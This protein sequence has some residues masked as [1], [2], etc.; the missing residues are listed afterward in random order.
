MRARC[1]WWPPTRSAPT[2]SPPIS[3]VLLAGALGPPE[4]DDPQVVRLPADEILPYDD[5]SPDRGTVLARLGALFHLRRGEGMRAVVVGARGLAQRLLPVAEIDAH[6]HSVAAGGPCDRDQLARDLALA[7][8]QHVPLVEDPG[9]FSVRG[10][11]VD[12]FSPLYDAPARLELFGDEIESIRFFNPETQRT[13]GETTRLRLAPARETLFT[14]KTIRLATL[15]ARELAAEVGRPTRQLRSLVDDIEQGRAAFG[16]EALLPGFFEGPLS[17]LAD[18][19]EGVRLAYVEDPEAVAEAV[20]GLWERA[21]DEFEAARGRGELAFPAERHYLDPAGALGVL[22]TMPVVAHVPLLVEGEATEA[23]ALNLAPTAFLHQEILDHHGED[24]ALTPLI[25]HLAAWRERGLAAVLA[26]Q[27]AGQADRLGRLLL[28]RRVMV[29]RHD[30]LPDLTRAGELYDP[31]VGAHLVVGDLDTGFVDPSSQV[32]LLSDADVLGAPPTRRR[33]ARRLTDEA[34]LASAFRELT[35]GDLVVHVEHGIGRYAGL[36]RLNL[37]GV[38]G[39]FLVVEYAGKDKIYLPVH[40]L[41]Q[42]QKYVGGDPEHVRLDR[43]GGQAF[44]VRKKKVKEELLKMAAELLDIYA[45]RKAHPGTAFSAPDA[46]FRE[47]EAEFPYEETVDQAEAIEAVLADMQRVEPMD[48]LVCG[49]VGFGKTE[50]AMRA[51]MKAVL[52]GKQV[53]V[54]VPTTVLAVQHARTFAARFGGYPVVVESLSRFRSPKEVKAVLKRVAEGK[55]DIL[56]GTHRLLS[57]DVS[58]HDLGLLVVDEEQR[59]GVKQK[60]ALK[61]LRR[62]VDVLTLTATPIPRTLHLS[63]SG[64][65]DLSIIATAPQDRRAVRTFVARFDGAVIK[66]AIERELQRGGQVF[67]VH[68]RVQSI[69]GVARYLE[70]LMPG[71]RMVVA[72]GQMHEHQLE[73]AMQAFISREVDVLLSSAII[74]SGLDIPTV[75]TIL[76]D[77]AD[78][79][80]LAQLYQLRGRVG[81]G[82][83]RAYCYL[84]VPARRPITREARQRLAVLQQLTELG[85]GLRLASHDL[86]IRGAGSLLGKAQSGQLAAVGFDLYAQM[87][88]DAVAE[89]KGEPPREAY[90]P[91][92]NLPVPAFIPDDYVPDVHQRLDLYKRFSHAEGPAELED[93]RMELVDRFGPVPEEALHLLELMAVK[94]RLAA[95]R[96]RALDAGPGRLVVTLGQDARL[97]GLRL[98]ERVAAA[99]HSGRLR[100][101]SELKLVNTLPPGT[102]GARFLE[103]ARHLLDELEACAQPG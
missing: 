71:L 84:L 23:L 82:A 13:T 7:G 9:T 40:R 11:L 1:W 2:A 27:S 12:V 38:E 50:V 15:A 19:L 41:G 8:Y 90:E 47:F 43:L 63:V 81:R 56:I 87:L 83:E 46:Y 5:L 65:R 26:C 35:E 22:G 14:P 42:V 91:E 64:I 89:L 33:R 39:D 73:R 80:G 76:I 60:E 53:A 55:V 102:A 68:N 30:P 36:T 18:Y 31:A 86:E 92:V 37:R 99:Q 103:A 70:R 25:H 74:E 95:L 6:G 66:E 45:A 20:A 57:R 54:L 24:G 97:D 3:E 17:P 98:A 10:G 29:R 34:A 75:N 93:L 78:M 67:V 88:E 59:F 100:L 28:D 21:Q 61:R 44:A 48:R 32:V 101:T 51:A 4:P 94:Q 52:D 85:S 72:H 49:D 96:L 58:F 62:Q 16:V 69:G 79:F 77:R